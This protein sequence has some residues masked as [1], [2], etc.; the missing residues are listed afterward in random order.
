MTNPEVKKREVFLALEGGGAKGLAHISALKAIETLDQE[1]E[2]S[3][4]GGLQIVGVAGTSAGAIVAAL[5]AAGYTADQLLDPENRSHLL[6]Q[7]RHQR[8]T[9]AIDLLG[10]TEWRKIAMFRWV[11]SHSRWLGVGLLLLLA[12][13]D[14]LLHHLVATPWAEIGLIVS[15]V[16]LFAILYRASLGVASLHSVREGI[17]QAL[18]QAFNREEGD[19]RVRFHDF[20]ANTRHPSLKIVATDITHGRM[21]LFSPETTPCI[22]VADAVAASICI[23][24][25]FRPWRIED[26]NTTFLDG[27]L[28]SNLPAWPFDEERLLNRQ[29]LTIAVEIVDSNHRGAGPAPLWRRALRLCWHGIAATIDRGQPHWLVPALRTAIFGAN[30]LNKRATGELELLSLDIDL[31]VLAF[32]T[33][34]DIVYAKL[35]EVRT[36]AENALQRGLIDIPKLMKEASASIQE[37][38]QDLIAGFDHLQPAPGR[39][40]VAFAIQDKSSHRSFQLR[41]GAGFTDADHDL[42]L[43]VPAEGSFIGTAS[44]RDLPIFAP[45]FPGLTS[46]TYG[47]EMNRAELEYVSQ[48]TWPE[49]KWCY[50]H[51]VTVSLLPSRWRRLVV[52]VD[53]NQ[54]LPDMSRTK[55]DEV[56]SLLGESIDLILERL[57]AILNPERAAGAHD[58]G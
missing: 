49:A 50:C 19:D 44:H 46:R 8:C 35:K 25:V 45:I 11:I 3:V 16:V 20:G 6:T 57:Y 4:G 31:D 14:H 36:G 10:R 38:A 9:D 12:A 53:G 23:P 28:V 5:V 2:S 29:A 58:H 1:L 39:I 34:A 27:G 37:I 33:P 41:H 15:G 22:P 55:V 56:M 21:F 47:P 26:L 54:N 42:H 30:E 51:P 43:I 7:L 32:D 48:R 52:L 17:D 24:L 40:R 13:T 18:K